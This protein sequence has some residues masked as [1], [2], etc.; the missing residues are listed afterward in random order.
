MSVSV[1][2]SYLPNDLPMSRTTSS[3]VF[4]TAD[5][6]YSGASG[7]SLASSRTSPES[8]DRE[9]TGRAAAAPGKISLGALK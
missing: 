7:A 6:G 8:I 4:S 3:S 2:T 1:T 9:R 5:S